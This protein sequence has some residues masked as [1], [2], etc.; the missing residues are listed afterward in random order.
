MFIVELE[1]FT[2][3]NY[4][5]EIYLSDKNNPKIKNIK[6]GRKSPKIEKTKIKSKTTIQYCSSRSTGSKRRLDVFL[7]LLMINFFDIPSTT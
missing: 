7:A 2:A 4:R 5:L 3:C 6:P 1:L